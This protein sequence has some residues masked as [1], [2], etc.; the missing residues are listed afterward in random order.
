[1]EKNG[2]TFDFSKKIEDDMVLVASWR[3]YEKYDLPVYGFH[4]AIKEKD[5]Y[6]YSYN[7]IKKVYN[8]LEFVCYIGA[9]IRESEH[10]FRTIMYQLEYGS[11]FKLV[12][13]KDSATDDKFYS[14]DDRMIT[15]LT[16]N[17]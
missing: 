4:C 7:D 3:K 12:K 10:Y 14:A 11:G 8:G 2:E 16:E 1:M 13:A 5:T 15:D 6:G 9:K 17:P